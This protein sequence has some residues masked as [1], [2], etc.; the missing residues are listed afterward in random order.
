MCLAL[1]LN[2]WYYSVGFISLGKEMHGG[3]HYR[4]SLYQL[5]IIEFIISCRCRRTNILWAIYLGTLQ[6]TFLPLSFHKIHQWANHPL[7]RDRE[8][9]PDFKSKN[10]SF[11]F[12]GSFFISRVQVVTNLIQMNPVSLWQ[13]A[14]RT[15]WL[16]FKTFGIPTVCNI[17]DYLLN[18]LWRRESLT[19]SCSA[20][21]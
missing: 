17:V 15:C 3:I 1:V 6:L 7:Q 5:Q 12:L 18:W 20:S 19:P 4:S 13:Y 11:Y 16:D 2:W 21:A 10:N 8:Y 9:E 14:A